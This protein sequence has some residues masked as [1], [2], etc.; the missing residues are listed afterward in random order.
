MKRVI[1][2]AVADDHG[3]VRAGLGQLFARQP[4]IELVGEASDGAEMY[5]LVK[6]LTPDVAVIDLQMPKISGLELVRM[7][8]KEV[9]R[10][11]VVLLTMFKK[12][13]YALQALQTGAMAYILKAAPSD[14]LIGAIR[15]AARGE[16]RLSSEINP[17]V[18]ED[19][20]HPEPN[21]PGTGE[22]RYDRLSD[23]E[24]EIFRLVVDGNSSRR[25]ADIL[26]ISPKTV[27]KHRSN[28]CR[29]LELS[30]P[31]S[32][33]RYAVKIGLADPDLW[34]DVPP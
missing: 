18:L 17:G 2:V 29:K 13:A 20:R 8:S 6:K 28:I 11:R 7:L 30:D 3:V 14:E 10:T 26:C 15:A 16:I 25:I 1:R 22:R 19:F 34:L 24:Q 33:L 32:M 21:R 12:E 31:A 4:D 5:R 27:E 9:P 23:R